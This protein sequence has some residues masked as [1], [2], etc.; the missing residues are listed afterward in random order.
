MSAFPDTPVT[1]LA[2]I[3]VQ[4]T[5]QS[6]EMAWVR[7]FGLY[8]PAIRKFAEYQGAK[9]EAEDISQDI[10]LRLVDVLRAGKY[11]SDVGKFRCYLATLIR[12]EVISHWRKRQARAA[13]DHISIDNEDV[14]VNLVS[15]FDAGT[16]LDLKWKL[17]RHEAAVEH[18]LTKTALSKQSK[19]IYRAYVIDELPI[20]EVAK[21]FGVSE[22]VV[23]QSKTRV[24]K[25]IAILEE[26]LENG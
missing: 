11:S 4:V 6:D 23:S 24:G 17:A 10:L 19:E 26:G 20:K 8:E 16:E 25:M 13:D 7:F 12:R 14:G 5:G 2:K 15:D 21:R 22:N 3:A 1:L 18:A 9:A